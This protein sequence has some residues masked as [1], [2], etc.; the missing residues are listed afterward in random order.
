MRIVIEPRSTSPRPA[1]LKSCGRA[2]GRASALEKSRSRAMPAC[3]SSPAAVFQRI[4][5][6]TAAG[7]DP[8][9]GI[10]RD[11]LF[12]SALALPDALPQL[13]SAAGLGDVERGSITIRM[14]FLDFDDYWQPL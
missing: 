5:W 3:G 7:L 4:L 11:R 13:F 14:N 12:S 6:D 1:A 8:Q 2:S 9:A 10:A